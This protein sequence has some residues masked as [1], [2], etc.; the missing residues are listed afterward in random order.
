MRLLLWKETSDIEFH[1]G[2]FN[3]KDTKGLKLPK[4][5]HVNVNIKYLGSHLLR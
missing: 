2:L 1:K 4:A 3:W 5:K